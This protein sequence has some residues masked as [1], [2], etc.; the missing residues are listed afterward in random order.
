MAEVLREFSQSVPGEDGLVYGAQ[1]VG[2]TMPDGRWEGWIEFIPLG[3]GT[4][5]RTPRE[6][7]QPTADDLA[8]WASGLTPVYLEGALHRAVRPFVQHAPQPPQP[9]FNEP[10]QAAV[11]TEAYPLPGTDAVLDPFEVGESGELMLRR[12]L[13]ALA[14][15]HLVRIIMAYHLS[16]EPLPTLNALS[17]QELIDLI[18][19][20]VM[21]RPLRSRPNRA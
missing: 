19:A 6:T 17:S 16:D 2:A 3:G 5:V 14:P 11:R 18:A 20:A 4:P 13:G 21:R 8:Y 15:E 1:A 10:A 7:T 9:M 12:K